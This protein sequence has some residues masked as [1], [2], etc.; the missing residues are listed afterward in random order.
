MTHFEVMKEY[1]FEEAWSKC[2]VITSAVELYEAKLLFEYAKKTPDESVILE[3]GSHWGRSTVL[4]AH[5]ARTVN[6]IDPLIPAGGNTTA[7]Y[8]GDDEIL[9]K[10]IAPYSNIHWTKK[11]SDDVAEPMT[12]VGFIFIDG[13][14]A[15]PQPKND[16]LNFIDYCLPGIYQAWHDYGLFDGVTQ[17]IEEL[18]TEGIIEIIDS[19]GTMV[20]TRLKNNA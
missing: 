14:H 8:E 18:K 6:N 16:L 12:P 15:Y 11:Y 10:N 3:I 2:S 20:I 9:E 4:L 17:S 1:S 13:N 7:I 5:C 19:C